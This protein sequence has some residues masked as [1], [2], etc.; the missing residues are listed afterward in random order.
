VKFLTLAGTNP[1]LLVIQPVARRYADYAITALRN[2]I[3][4]WKK[5]HPG[6]K[7]EADNKTPYNAFTLCVSSKE[8]RPEGGTWC[9]P[10]F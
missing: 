5:C 8:N 7:H 2:I 10:C 4:V 3:Y 6:Y 1:D 9:E